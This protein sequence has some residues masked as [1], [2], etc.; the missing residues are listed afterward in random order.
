MI[1]VRLR[2]GLGNQL[3]QYASAKALA[4]HKGVQLK[5]DLYTYTKHPLRTYELKNFNIEL[6]EATRDEVHRF[7]G[8]NLLI[9]YIYKRENYFH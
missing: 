3:F 4:M 8:S 6:P 9:R 7:T 1:I 5:A 2:G